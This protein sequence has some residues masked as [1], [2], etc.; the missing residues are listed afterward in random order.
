VWRGVFSH[1][2][3][4]EEALGRGKFYLFTG[5]GPSSK[6]LQ[7]SHLVPFMLCK[8]LQ[9]KFKCPLIIQISNDEKYF[10]GKIS[11]LSTDN[12]NLEDILK[13]DFDP[14]LTRIIIDTDLP[15]SLDN[16]VMEL[17]K[18]I[19]LKQI[20]KYFGFN[21]DSCLG[22]IYYPAVQIAPTF[23]ENLQSFSDLIKDDYS[24]I[25][26][27]GIDQSP[28]FSLAGDLHK[29]KNHKSSGLSMIYN[30]FLPGLSGQGKASSSIPS[31]AIFLDDSPKTIQSK[32]KSAFSDR[33]NLYQDVTMAYL[34][35]F[36]SDEA[37]YQYIKNRYS[38][39]NM[40]S[41]ELKEYTS[42]FLID[43]SAKFNLQKSVF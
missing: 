22:N 14:N 4:V 10:A 33:V 34:E 42:K 5:R 2:K 17:L 20:K 27:A 18:N 11:E 24:C 38:R 28:Y 19:Q 7:F 21:D 13:F 29:K 43:I 26:V 16:G 9:T 39:E 1:E 35:A 12:L 6:S 30:K 31:S 15:K 8:H 40:S 36:L 3:H 25:V 32:I 41:L 37:E 23:S